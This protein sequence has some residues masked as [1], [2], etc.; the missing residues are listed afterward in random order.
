[1]HKL[2]VAALEASISIAHSESIQ[3][4]APLGTDPEGRAFYAL[5]PGHSEREAAYEFTEVLSGELGVTQKLKKKGRTLKLSE[6]EDQLDWSWMILVWGKKP[7]SAFTPLEEDEDGDTKMEEEEEE[8]EGWWCFSE[9]EDIK[10]LAEWLALAN[11]LEDEKKDSKSA[12]TNG[13]AATVLD[14]EQLAVKAVVGSLK[15]FGTLLE[16]RLREEKY[17]LPGP[18]PSKMANGSTAGSA[19][20]RMK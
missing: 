15:D 3:R 4:F 18:L 14:S 16:W 13:A 8:E 17:Q 9:P 10:K 1:M 20:G 5:T 19:K 6:R 2:I 11:D 7:P 12:S